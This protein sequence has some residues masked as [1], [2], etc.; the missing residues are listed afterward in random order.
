MYM[1]MLLTLLSLLI[2][3]TYLVISKDFGLAC[4]NFAF[5]FKNCIA[6]VVCMR[7]IHGLACTDFS[8][9]KCMPI[10]TMFA[11]ISY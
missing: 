3:H 4:T 1:Y 8:N 7:I 6:E 11:K 2:A 9:Y 10:V 5:F